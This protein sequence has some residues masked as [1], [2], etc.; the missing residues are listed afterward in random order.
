[1]TTID[2]PHRCMCRNS[3]CLIFQVLTDQSCHMAITGED[4]LCDECRNFQLIAHCHCGLGRDDIEG[5]YIVSL[6]KDT[7]DT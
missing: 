6:R 3:R 2:D 7:H 5:D 1:M 4:L